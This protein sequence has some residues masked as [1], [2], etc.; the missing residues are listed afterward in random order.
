VKKLKIGARV[1]VFF[2]HVREY[3]RRYA[4]SRLGAPLKPRARFYITPYR[5]VRDHSRERG[6]FIVHVDTT[7]GQRID[8]GVG[9]QW[10]LGDTVVGLSA[11][12][13]FR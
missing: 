7:T 6:F 12:V 11:T 3:V 13:R 2:G 8:R 1:R 4:L 9:F 5:I 10:P